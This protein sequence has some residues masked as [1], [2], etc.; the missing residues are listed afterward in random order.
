MNL[1]NMHAHA[2]AHTSIEERKE[3]MTS[4]ALTLIVLVR[5]V[6]CFFRL[7]TFVDKPLRDE[8]LNVKA[9]M[10][11]YKMHPDIQK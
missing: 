8:H 9:Q 10:S 3:E 11:T 7:T 1:S 4:D 6:T 2:Y 5:V